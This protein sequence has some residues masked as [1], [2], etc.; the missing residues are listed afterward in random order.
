MPNFPIS[1]SLA[2]RRLVHV[3]ERVREL[4]KIGPG[5]D[6]YVGDWPT[7]PF[8]TSESPPWLNGFQNTLGRRVRF[9][10]GFDGDLDI[11]GQFDLL[12][13]SPVSGDTAFVLPPNYRVAFETFI[14]LYLGGTDWSAAVVAANE[15]TGSVKV[16]WPIVANP[17]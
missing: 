16:Y 15:M 4:Q 9:R 2:P 7:E 5:K 13:G 11:Y 14:P 6:V 17:I 3:E 8:T 10:W 1:A 12:T